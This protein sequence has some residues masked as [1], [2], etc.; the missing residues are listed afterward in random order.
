MSWVTSC[1]W[2]MSTDGMYIATNS[3]LG[4]WSFWFKII[5]HLEWYF[6]SKMALVIYLFADLRADISRARVAK[7]KGF[8]N[9]CSVERGLSAGCEPMRI[10]SV[11]SPEIFDQSDFSYL[12]D[13]AAG[14]AP[15]TVSIHLS[16]GDYF[17]LLYSGLLKSQKSRICSWSK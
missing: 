6:Y 16:S 5:Q 9:G 7:A 13:V 11:F 8:K 14:R 12:S 4:N 3:S 2:L 17:S 1:F 15:S 10:R